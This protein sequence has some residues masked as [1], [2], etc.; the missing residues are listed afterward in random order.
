[1]MG[2]ANFVLWLSIIWLAVVSGRFS[3]LCLRSS[4]W[5]F[6]LRAMLSCK[7]IR[8]GLR[9]KLSVVHKLPKNDSAKKFSSVP[10]YVILWRVLCN[11]GFRS[12]RVP[13]QVTLSPS[14]TR[15]ERHQC[16]VSDL[17]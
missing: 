6:A 2:R 17:R 14:I 12:G 16:V 8:A 4:R 10:L 15:R 7:Q 13:A 11:H 3:S 1:M 5:Q 9:P